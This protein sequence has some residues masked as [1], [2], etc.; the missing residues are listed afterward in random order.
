MQYTTEDVCNILSEIVKTPI[1]EEASNSVELQCAL[2]SLEKIYSEENF[3][4][5]Y[6]EISKKLEE[7]RPEERDTL[8]TSLE[9]ILALA[10]NRQVKKSTI[11]NIFKLSDH[12]SLENLRLN[13]MDALK[14]I[15]RNI[16]EI[17]KNSKIRVATAVAIKICLFRSS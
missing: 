6:F 10:E 16:V 15:E 14:H 7:F 12:V 4:H 9:I 5:S 3:R 17:S 11:T 2:S 13:R 1:M 8:T